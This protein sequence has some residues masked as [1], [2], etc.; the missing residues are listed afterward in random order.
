MCIRDRVKER[1]KPEL[2]AALSTRSALPIFPW[3][4]RAKACPRQTLCAFFHRRA[5]RRRAPT[6][7]TDYALPLSEENLPEQWVADFLAPPFRDASAGG[8]SLLEDDGVLDSLDVLSNPQYSDAV[9]WDP[10]DPVKLSDTFLNSRPF[11]LPS[12]R[13]IP[14]NELHFRDEDYEEDVRHP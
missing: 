13:S 3:D 4:L 5:E 2:C 8:A 1:C 9:L 14:I 6:D 10:Y 12:P 7:P 11:A